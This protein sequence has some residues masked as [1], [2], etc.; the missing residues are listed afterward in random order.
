VAGREVAK[1]FVQGA[2]QP[3]PVADALIPLLDQASPER[4]RALAGLADVRSRLGTPGAAARVA[5][6]AADLTG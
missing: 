2:L 1:E 5:Q 3:A 4:M 6:M